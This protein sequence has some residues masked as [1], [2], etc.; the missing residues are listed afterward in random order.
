MPLIEKSFVRHDSEQSLDG[1]ESALTVGAHGRIDVADACLAQLPKQLLARPFH[2]ARS[3][4][5]ILGS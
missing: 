2:V 4:A 5:A 1:G 3:V